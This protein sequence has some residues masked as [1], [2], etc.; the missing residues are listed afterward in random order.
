MEE[1]RALSAGKL[2][3]FPVRSIPY[4][5]YAVEGFLL[6]F[7]GTLTV[8]AI[9]LRSI[10]NLWFFFIVFFIPGFLT[11]LLSPVQTTW[12][13]GLR[14]EIVVSR[15]NLF[16]AWTDRYPC[17]DIAQIRIEAMGRARDLYDIDITLKSSNE[18]VTLS[19]TWNR[20]RA[21]QELDLVQQAIRAMPGAE[22][23][24]PSA[25]GPAS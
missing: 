25:I 23:S 15:R 12:M 13:D 10:P 16:R 11:V 4:G 3:S 5:A 18:D 14:Q 7:G 22:Q 1:S 21:D 9:S 19:W 6:I 8:V 24:D 17:A 2:V 20:K